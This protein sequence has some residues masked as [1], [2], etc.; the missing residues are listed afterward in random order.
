MDNKIFERKNKKCK[1]SI[2][3]NKRGELIN[4]PEN[5]QEQ[6]VKKIVKTFN[7]DSKFYQIGDI[8]ES[9]NRHFLVLSIERVRLFETSV[10]VRSEEHT[11]ELQSRGHLVC[12]LLH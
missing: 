5:E 9:D 2:R 3:G 8:I 4:M 7:F 12:S 1:L 6:L 10:V 11:S